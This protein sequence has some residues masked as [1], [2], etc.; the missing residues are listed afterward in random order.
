M[1]SDEG[2][3][4][5]TGNEVADVCANKGRSGFWNAWNEMKGPKIA[6]D[7]AMPRTRRL[8]TVTRSS[9]CSNEDELEKEDADSEDF[10]NN[11]N[12]N[13]NNNMAK[14]AR[15]HKYPMVS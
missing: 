12:N 1:G 7:W 10:N 5:D 6:P 9:K 4:G 8:T 3:S 2:H 11:N 13:N 14:K 15:T